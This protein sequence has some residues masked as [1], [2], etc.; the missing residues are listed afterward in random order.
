[1]RPPGISPVC[2]KAVTILLGRAGAVQGLQGRGRGAVAEWRVELAPLVLLLRAAPQL[3]W[4][5]WGLVAATPGT[6]QL[7]PGAGFSIGQIF[8]FLLNH[9]L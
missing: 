4:G 3:P 5:T 1:M 2:P 8:L 7:Y 6:A 9:D